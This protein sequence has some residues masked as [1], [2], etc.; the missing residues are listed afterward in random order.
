MARPPAELF[1]RGRSAR[2]PCE[3]I[4]LG[5]GSPYC[6]KPVCQTCSYPATASDLPAARDT[7]PSYW[8]R[9]QAKMRGATMVASDSMMNF[10][11][12]AESLPHVIFSLGTAPE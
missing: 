9:T 3:Q 12:A 11:V 8:P 10:G 6:L 2:G 7:P 1:S 5:K 4:R